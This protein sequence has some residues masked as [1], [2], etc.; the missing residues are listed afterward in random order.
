MF[1]WADWAIIAILTL[2]ALIS[3]K[4]GFV[5]EAMS[6][7]IWVVALVVASIFSP[8]LAPLLAAYI[9]APS[10]QQ[11]AAF[12]SL[13]IATLLI[14]GAVNYL[15]ATLIKATG[16]SG[17]DRMLGVIFGLVRGL[18]IVMV[19][20]LYGPKLIP[21]AEDLWWQE[22]ALIPKFLGFEDRFSLLTSSVY[23]Y[24]TQFFSA[25]SE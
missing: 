15:L 16:L 24:I 2:S 17:T 5:K 8:K 10:L 22:S 1:N 25:E 18:I 19:I 7:A 12:S 11:M 6:L 20:L 3:L 9:D 13:F 21:V 14:G 4:R 23:E